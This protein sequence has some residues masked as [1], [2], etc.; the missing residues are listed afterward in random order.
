MMLSLSILEYEPNLAQHMDNLEESDSFSE[1]I[2]LIRTNKLHR[3][4]IDIMRPPMIPHRTTF[5]TDWIEQ[6]YK[7]LHERILL[8]AHLMVLNPFPIIREMDRFIPRND[9]TDVVLTVQR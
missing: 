2:R 4:H 7:R 6:L 8:A 9:R 1:I 3:V 5:S